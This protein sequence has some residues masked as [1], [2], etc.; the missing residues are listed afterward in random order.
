MTS[1]DAA[2]EH[3]YWLCRCHGFRVDSPRGELGTV[4]EVLPP[5]SS[6]R[7]DALAI[8]LDEREWPLLVVAADEVDQIFPLDRRLRLRT[9][10]IPG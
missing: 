4:A 10:P 2:G 3:D 6:A 9:A 5:S 8:A 1:T 7:P